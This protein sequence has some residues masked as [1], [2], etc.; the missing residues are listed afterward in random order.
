[1]KYIGWLRAALFFICGIGSASAQDL[2]MGYLPALEEGDSPTLSIVPARALS[3]MQV[4]L[5]VGGDT[6]VYSPVM[7]NMS[8]STSLANAPQRYHHRLPLQPWE[9]CTWLAHLMGNMINSRRGSSTLQ[10]GW[11]GKLHL[12]H[13]WRHH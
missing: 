10:Q 8:Y 5:Q 7:D 9:F 6:Q 3:E 12:L 11:M 2:A 1:M 4:D 13:Q